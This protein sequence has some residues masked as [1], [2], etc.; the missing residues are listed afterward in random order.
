MAF[1]KC[2]IIS[3]GKILQ[4]IRN[5]VFRDNEVTKEISHGVE[6][7]ENEKVPKFWSIIPDPSNAGSFTIK[8]SSDECILANG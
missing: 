8:N 1:I 6:G 3:D 4:I 5:E 2:N 7:H